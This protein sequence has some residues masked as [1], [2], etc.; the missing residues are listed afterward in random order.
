MAK[1]SANSVVSTPAPAP[2][3]THSA[4]FRDVD[5]LTNS[6]G[7]TS[8]ISQR[9]RD[10]RFTFALFKVY[11]KVQDDGTLVE[12]KT[13]FFTEDMADGYIEHIKLTMERIEQLKSKPELLPFEIRT[14]P[15]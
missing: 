10:G 14:P 7:I 11:P 5:R 4:K 6:A 15:R 1:R 8:V 3:E 2:F 13:A 12:E 9:A